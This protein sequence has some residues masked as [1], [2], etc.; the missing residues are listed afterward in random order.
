[1]PEGGGAN[2]FKHNLVSECK[3]VLSW[4]NKMP[5]FIKNI[6]MVN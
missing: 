6:K 3:K 5:N 4:R 2:I 1:M